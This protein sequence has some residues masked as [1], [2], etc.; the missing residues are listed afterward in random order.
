MCD[1]TILLGHILE[2]TL[3]YFRYSH[4]CLYVYTAVEKLYV[5]IYIC[6]MH[7]YKTLNNYVYIFQENIIRKL[8]IILSACVSFSVFFTV[9]TR[10]QQCCCQAESRR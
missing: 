5:Y 7:I 10:N 8:K 4:V 6:Y 3:D 1:L 9:V 2:Y